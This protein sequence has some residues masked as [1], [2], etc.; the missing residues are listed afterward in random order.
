MHGRNA[1]WRSLAHRGLNERNATSARMHRTHQSESLR[2]LRR[3]IRRCRVAGA[4][5]HFG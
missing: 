4:D 1:F 2:L 5:E 3:R